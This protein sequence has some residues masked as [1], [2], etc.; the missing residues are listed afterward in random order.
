MTRQH[1]SEASSPGRSFIHDAYPPSPPNL[2]SR[3]SPHHWPLPFEN[4][5]NATPA[6]PVPATGGAAVATFRYQ[7]LRILCYMRL[8]LRGMRHLV[9]I[10]E[11]ETISGCPLK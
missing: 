10:Q 1:A 6:F 9:M 7:I 4:G 3:S 8:H 11:F 5:T 2:P